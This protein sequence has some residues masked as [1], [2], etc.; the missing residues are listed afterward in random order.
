MVLEGRVVELTRENT[1]LKAELH[2]I[3]DKFGLSLG[4]HFIESEGISLAMPDNSSRGRRNKLISTI[5]NSNY[6]DECVSIVK[7]RIAD[8]EYPSSM[9]Q[10]Y[11]SSSSPNSSSSSLSESISP[12]NGCSTNSPPNILLNISNGNSTNAVSV[13]SSL[14]HKLR[15]KAKPVPIDSDSG[16]DSSAQVN[17]DCG[18]NAFCQQESVE[19]CQLASIDCDL[20]E[21]NSKLRNELQRL[22][23]EVNSLKHYFTNSANKFCKDFADSCH[24][25]DNCRESGDEN[26]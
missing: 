25:G 20:K 1:I 4:Q 24:Y 3:K 5:V 10:N 23:T 18:T 9:N 26:G 12:S 8:H 14:P 22:A 15:H 17:P 7:P 21:E 11:V 16:S 6:A 13:T 2:A 19:R